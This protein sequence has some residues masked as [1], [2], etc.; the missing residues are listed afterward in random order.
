MRIVAVKRASCRAS[1]TSARRFRPHIFLR[2][3]QSGWSPRSRG[4]RMCF[5]WLGVCRSSLFGSNL[6][7]V[8]ANILYF[9]LFRCPSPH[10]RRSESISSHLCRLVEC[11][12]DGKV[13]Q[14]P[15]LNTICLSKVPLQGRRSMDKHSCGTTIQIYKPVMFTLAF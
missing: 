9:F 11:G 1:M 12:V 10:A 5:L 6:S 8:W 3:P 13:C 7:K 2:S 14:P 15:Y 4:P